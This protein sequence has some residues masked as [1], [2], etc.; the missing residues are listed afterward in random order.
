[1]SIV[2]QPRTTINAAV[3]AELLRVGH[4]GDEPVEPVR[5]RRPRPLSPS[6][7]E[8]EAVRISEECAGPVGDPHRQS[9]HPFKCGAWESLYGELYQHYLDAQAELRRAR[10]ELAFWPERA[11]ELA[12]AASYGTGGYNS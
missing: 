10:T 7:A 12:D 6:Q 9:P 3:A 1:V 11:A 4:T 2:T 8:A 5:Y